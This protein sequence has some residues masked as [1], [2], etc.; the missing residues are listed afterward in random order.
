MNGYSLKV[1][2]RNIKSL[3]R[4]W[5]FAIEIAQ[6]FCY[7]TNSSNGLKDLPI[8][9][10]AMEIVCILLLDAA[11]ST[12]AGAG[13]S[14]MTY[15]FTSNLTNKSFFAIQYLEESLRL[16]RPRRITYFYFDY[17][18]KKQSA[19]DLLASLLKQ[20]ASP[21]ET[22]PHCLNGLYGNFKPEAPRP[23][24][25]KLLE[26][27]VE[28]AKAYPEVFVFLDAFDEC[29]PTLCA[30][31]VS[32]VKRL[33][34]EKIKVWV[35][36]QPGRLDDLATEGLNDAI[37]AEIKAKETDV[38][39]Y[40]NAK[41]RKDSVDNKL[42]MEIVNTISSGVDGMY[43]ACIVLTDD[44]ISPCKST[45]RYGCSRGISSPHEG[46]IKQVAQESVRF[47]YE[48]TRAYSRCGRACKEGCVT[49]AGMDLPR[50]KQTRNGRT[51]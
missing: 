2:I 50:Q 30:H 48:R 4:S 7:Q 34:K 43:D 26:L 19:V 33:H 47:V 42:R 8:Y 5:N 21:L 49:C 18:V 20:L 24:Q 35:T 16:H 14:F 28:C 15:S 32:I 13:K 39:R 45:N 37:K 31:V 3:A 17:S 12:V 46:A 9:Y 29:D 41:L 40:V 11:Y 22:M 27:F 10:F 23:D 44:Q 38:A 36:T 51:P 6:N 25:E 1:Y